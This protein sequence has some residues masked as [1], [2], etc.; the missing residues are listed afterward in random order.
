MMSLL[1]DTI[2][3]TEAAKRDVSLDDLVLPLD[4]VALLAEARALDSYRRGEPDLYRRIRSLCFLSEVY[5]FHIVTRLGSDLHSVSPAHGHALLADG[6]PEEAVEVFLHAEPGPE[7]SP[8]LCTSLASAYR[9]L[10]FVELARQVRLSV[11]SEPY[12]AFLFDAQQPQPHPPPPASGAA[13][14]P[15]EEKFV[16]PSQRLVLGPAQPPQPRAPGAFVLPSD[17]FTSSK[18]L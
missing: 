11:Q 16:L 13:P 5:R 3:A 9:Q 4:L 15:A 17:R 6:A 7:R 2:T 10:A 1:V 8:A 12:N 14:A 18:N